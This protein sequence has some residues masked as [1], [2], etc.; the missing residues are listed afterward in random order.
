MISSSSSEIF[1]FKIVLLGEGA[2]GKTSI[3][4]RYVED[5]FNDKHISTLQ[6]SFLNKKL[7]IAGKRV[8]LAIWD[9]AGQEKFHALGPIYYRMSNGAV[10]NWVKE[11]KK[12][13][14]NEI[15]IVI[16]GNKIDL[17][18]DRTVSLELAE[19]YAKQVEAEHYLVSAKLNRGIEELFLQLT[20]KM[21]Q[22]AEEQSR[23]K[24]NAINRGGSLRGN[25]VII[26]DED[27]EELSNSGYRR[28]CCTGPTN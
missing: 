13:L 6:A 26:N 20:Q 17:E 22:K 3:V 9:T 10:K 16:V 15:C 18:K 8:N 11:L 12:M 5:K 7:N 2:V 25:I 24:E 23:A 1:N 14:G 28:K 27:S 4:L 21:L 19:Q